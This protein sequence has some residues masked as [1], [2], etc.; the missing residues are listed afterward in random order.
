MRTTDFQIQKENEANKLNNIAWLVSNNSFSKETKDTVSK[1]VNDAITAIV[2]NRNISYKELTG[3]DMDAQAPSIESANI[4]QKN[5]SDVRYIASEITN[6]LSDMLF[7]NNANYPRYIIDEMTFKKYIPTDEFKANHDKFKE[8]IQQII[9][10][11]EKNTPVEEALPETP[12]PEAPTPEALPETP[13]QDPTHEE[14]PEA[15]APEPTK[16]D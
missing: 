3:E 12:T 6:T 14:T 8:S 15:P 1:A 4:G 5:K 13:P 16:V 2:E 10:A 11:I 7:G 9:D